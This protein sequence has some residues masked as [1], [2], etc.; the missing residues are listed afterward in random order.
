MQVIEVEE[1]QKGR[2]DC[3]TADVG[4][5]YISLYY[6]IYA[7]ESHFLMVLLN[8]PWPGLIPALVLPGS[9]SLLNFL[10]GRDSVNHCCSPMTQAE[11]SNCNAAE[12]FTKA[13]HEFYHHKCPICFCY[14]CSHA[15]NSKHTLK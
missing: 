2:M 3:T 6:K 15:Q 4:Y 14:N 11:C 13:V 9:P 7:I 5:C 8:T 1:T 10:L 12:A